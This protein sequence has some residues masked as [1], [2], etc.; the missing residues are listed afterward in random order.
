M[1]LLDFIHVFIE[2]AVQ[3]VD[4]ALH[5]KP[6]KDYL[7]VHL[8]EK[9]DTENEKVTEIVQFLYPSFQIKHAIALFDF[10]VKKMRERK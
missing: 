6:L 9:Y 7:E 8:Q 1:E 10:V 3:L 2:D 4:E 5:E